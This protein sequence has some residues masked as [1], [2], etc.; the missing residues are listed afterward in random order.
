MAVDLNKQL[1]QAQEAYHQL[2]IGKSAVEFR[3]SNGEMVRYTNV[4]ANKLYGYILNLQHQ[5]GF[6]GGSRPMGVTFG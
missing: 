1:E 5:L 3:D 2:M 6:P 4:S